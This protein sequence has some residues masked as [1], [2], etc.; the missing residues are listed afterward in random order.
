MNAKTAKVLCMICM[1]ATALVFYM[2]SNINSFEF[3][4]FMMAGIMG[5]ILWEL[6]GVIF[7]D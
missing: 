1:L 3:G 7:N 4:K 6:G 5:V 2:I